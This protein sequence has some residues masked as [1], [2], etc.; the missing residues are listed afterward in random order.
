ML[1]HL[2]PKLPVSYPNISDD[3]SIPLYFFMFVLLCYTMHKNSISFL[4]LIPNSQKRGSNLAQ[5]CPK[6]RVLWYKH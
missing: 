1:K 5:L 3:L 4:V 2:L 6:D